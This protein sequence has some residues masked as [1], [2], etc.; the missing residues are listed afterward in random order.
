MPNKNEST[1]VE[2]I[3][4]TQQSAFSGYAPMINSSGGLNNWQDVIA[5]NDFDL[6]S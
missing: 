6:P 1:K 4:F 3:Q 2:L 5:D